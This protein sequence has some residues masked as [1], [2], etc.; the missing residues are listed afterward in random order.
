MR[1]FIVLLLSISLGK[2]AHLLSPSLGNGV[3]LIALI[4]LGVVPYL[5]VP[6]RSEFFRKKIALWAK[7]SN[8]KI[9]N[10]ESKSLF[11]GRLFWRVSDAQN[12]FFVKATDTR[13]WAAC[14]SWLLGAYSGSVLI[15]KV[16][17]RDLRLISV[18]NDAGLQ[19]K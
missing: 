4:F 10:I 2:L 1:P 19:V 18:C 12:V 9:V 15:Y 3:F 8:I 14:G 7:G 6:I 17:G 11:K 13:Y 5:L 16:V